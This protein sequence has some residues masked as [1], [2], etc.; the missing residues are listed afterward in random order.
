[1]TEGPL[2]GVKV[3]EFGA[4]GPVPFCAMLLAD[5]GADVVHVGRPGLRREARFDV[6][7]RGR[8]V[9]PLDLKRDQ[10]K[11]VALGLIGRADILLEGNRPGVMERL[12]LGPD[13]CHARNPRLV[14][15]RMTGWGQD[16]PLAPTAGHDI[17]YIALTG[18]L[19]AI[20]PA[21]GGPVPPLNLVGDYG[22]GAMFLAFGV[23]C[24]LLEAR[25]S[26]KGQVVDAAMVDGAAT[27]MALFCGLRAR[28]AWTD[29]R[30]DNMLDGGAPWYAAY[31]TADGKHVAVGA[32]EE[33]FW[34]ELLSRLGIAPGTLP[35][36]ED[37]A[38]WEVIR[39][40][41][42]QAF[43]RR[44][45]EE[46]AATFRDSDACVSPVMALGEAMDHDHIA[47]RGCFID[48]DGVTQP[49][50]APRLSRTPG[51]AR[52]AAE[53]PEVAAAVHADW[54]V[55][56]RPEAEERVPAM[57]ASA[58]VSTGHARPGQERAAMPPV[59]FRDTAGK[60]KQE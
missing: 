37:R 12:G 43:R 4:I 15:G 52:P 51:R 41:L 47:A 2:A 16:G 29:R 22:G 13:A 45:R 18:A 50:P 26:G 56:P 1:M 59:P 32:L 21:Q 54:G 53:G 60:E 30:G 44:T 46:W 6:T 58:A 9:I 3:I 14:Y 38:G 34:Q 10:D 11:A 28:G 31:E 25:G 36:R 39:A 8:R 49:A 55:D 7:L 35:P 57:T 5:M 24:A 19:H 20:G 48:L 40:A 42:A 27:L 17:N 33:P 23:L